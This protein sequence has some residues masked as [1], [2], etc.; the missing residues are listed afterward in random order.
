MP[1]HAVTEHRCQR[2]LTLFFHEVWDS[3][4]TA[5]SY[6][7][8]NLSVSAKGG[9]AARSSGDS[10]HKLTGEALWE[11]GE[12]AQKL[13]GASGG[14]CVARVMG[15]SVEFGTSGFPVEF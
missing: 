1:P 10:R 9:R 8:V 5:R 3:G 6:P 13:G 15:I 11:G 4:D 7:V 12:K 14:A 2:N